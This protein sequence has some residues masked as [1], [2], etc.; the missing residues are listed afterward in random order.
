MLAERID[1]YQKLKNNKELLK[2]YCYKTEKEYK[3]EFPFL[4]EI[5]SMALQQARQNLWKAFRYFYSG[6]KKGKKVGFPRFKNKKKGKLSYRDNQVAG[7]LRI[8]GTYLNLLKLGKVKFRG[9]SKNFQGV[10]KAVTV[11][12]SRSRKYYASILTEFESPI[13]KESTSDNILGI[14]LGLKEFL[15][16]SNGDVF[17]GVKEVLVEV[18]KQIKNQQRCIARK[19]KGSRRR[20]GA[21]V[22]LNRLY[23]R[24]RSILDNFQWH[25]VNRL[26]C[27][28]QAISLEDL[29]VSGM[30][31]N[32]KLSGSIQR[33]NWGSFVRK[34]EH[35]AVEY[36]TRIYKIDRFFPSS[37]MCSVC[38]NIKEDLT[39]KDRLYICVCGSVID[40]DL[41]AAINI[42]NY[43]INNISAEL[44]DY[45]HGE[46][47]S[48]G[49][50]IYYPEGT[51]RRSV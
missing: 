42:R 24:H 36:G 37:K 40:R 45:K 27:E 13:V 19:R 46:T 29:N 21:I 6:I 7:V 41:N 39:L 23:D 5:S 15:V 22:K 17:S 35:K 16:G 48:P 1:V 10:I 51:F 9:L 20:E 33:A 44:V 38:G 50:V 3:Q 8:E 31:R 14:D 2:S 34:L 28:N 26:C 49:R 11:T 12:K 4:K 32:R 25:L 43:Y 18:E 47:V 30:L